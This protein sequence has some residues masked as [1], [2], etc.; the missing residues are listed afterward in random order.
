MRR[1]SILVVLGAAGACAGPEV[2]HD[3]KEIVVC[4]DGPTVEGIDVSR[5]QG[6]IDW[7]RVRA[8]GV[9]FAFIRVSDGLNTPDVYF[10]ANWRGA[11][12]AG[13]IRGVYQF[14]R[15]AQDP[16]A[17]AEL[18]L[19][20]MGTLE[21]DDLPPVIDVEAGDGV[22][23][24]ALVA[25][26]RRWIDHVQA[27]TRRVPIIYAGK[28]SWP[29]LTGGADMTE[30]PLWIPQY[31]PTCPDI[32]A[33]WTSWRFFQYSST[34]RVDGITGAVDLDVWNGDLASLQ[35]FAA[36]TV[37]CGDGRCDAGE[38]ADGCAVDCSPCGVIE[39]A[40]GIVD[41]GD[42]CFVAGGPSAY[43]RDVDGAGW[44]GN[45]VW[46]HATA[47]AAQANFATWHLHLAEAGRYRVEVYTDGAWAE[48]H[49]AGY[50]VRHAGAEETVAI[51][52]TQ[53]D[54]W[55]TVGELSFAA[56]G[57]Q[58]I[59]LGDNTGESGADDVQLVFD[60]IRL[61]RLDPAP[62]P[63]PDPDDS[64]SGGCAAGSGGGSAAGGMLAVG[65]MAL[66]RRRRTR[67]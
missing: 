30:H 7:T 2:G 29:E 59:H 61:T 31:G 21:A 56:G 49:Q 58:W 24:E 54:G 45:L 14:F 41:D 53:H 17:Q 48:S 1:T 36:Q 46:T 47:S 55:Q 27:A 33:P 19:E 3:E 62:E 51:D 5:Y 8:A 44:G 40:G 12:E 60:A 35:A 32:P 52:Q 20:R 25:N 9:R 39:A 50:V 23:Q 63:A 42:A 37:A 34:G 13:V 4:A 18:M 26:V 66:R 43:L 38:D 16:I 10:D 65:M 6:T 15:P 64:L 67:T 28:Y 57:D 22:S 11:R